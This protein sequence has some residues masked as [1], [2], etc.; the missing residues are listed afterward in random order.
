MGS[1]NDSKNSKWNEQGEVVD[2]RV[3]I[4]RRVVNGNPTNLERRRGPGRRLSDFVKSAEEGEMTGEQFLFLMAI[5]AFKQ[6]NGKTFP[7]WSD[8]LEIVRKLGYRK[9]MA[10]ELKLGSRVQDWTE[11]ADAPSGLDTTVRDELEDAA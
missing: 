4:D 6:V 11:R 8:V 1:S 3:G 2:R 5:D 9:T 10:S 7:A